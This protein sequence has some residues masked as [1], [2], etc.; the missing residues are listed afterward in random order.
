MLPKPILVRRASCIVHC[1][2]VKEAHALHKHAN[3]HTKILQLGNMGP[4]AKP[5]RHYTNDDEQ[6]KK[7]HRKTTAAIFPAQ[8]MAS[9]FARSPC[10]PAPAWGKQPNKRGPS[11]IRTSPVLSYSTPTRL[12]VSL[13]LCRRKKPNFFCLPSHAG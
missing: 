5:I 6:P 8:H 3:Y 10:I 13:G 7:K 1:A 9:D 4:K 2:Y 12:R 11:D